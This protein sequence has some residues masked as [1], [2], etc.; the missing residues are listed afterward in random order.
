MCLSTMLSI[1]SHSKCSGTTSRRP[2]RC[3]SKPESVPSWSPI[4]S[5]YAAP[6][7]LLFSFLTRFLYSS[8]IIVATELCS[9]P[10]NPTAP[11]KAQPLSLARSMAESLG[12]GI[13]EAVSHRG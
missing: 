6:L 2:Q 5:L 8:S 11:P 3:L 7:C 1:S 12:S 10:T 13:S 9:S 4:K